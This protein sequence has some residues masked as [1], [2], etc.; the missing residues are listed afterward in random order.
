LAKQSIFK[1]K[2]WL[3]PFVI[4][5][6]IYLVLASFS[7]RKPLSGDEVYDLEEVRT[8]TRGTYDKI[9]ILGQDITFTH[10]PLY[11]LFL[12]FLSRL[13]GE[14]LFLFRSVGLLTLCSV[15]FLLSFFPFRILRDPAWAKR[16]SWIAPLLVA[17]H[18]VSVQGSAILDYESTFFLLFLSLFCFFWLTST[19]SIRSLS[20]LSFLY[21]LCLWG[22]S[23]SALILPIA[24]GVWAIFMRPQK[25]EVISL[26][27]VLLGGLLIFILSWGLFVYFIWGSGHF[28]KPFA[29]LFDRVGSAGNLSSYSLQDRIQDLA[30]FLIWFGVP[31]LLLLI[32]SFV[33][34]IP[35]SLS[36][37]EGRLHFLKALLFF[38]IPVYHVLGRSSWGYPK[39]LTP[40]AP[41]ATFFFTVLTTEKW[42]SFRGREGLSLFFLS[43][44]IGLSSFLLIGDPLYELCYGLKKSLVMGSTLLQEFPRLLWIFGLPTLF[45]FMSLFLTT[46]W[47]K[48]GTDFSPTWPLGCAL[49]LFATQLPF[50]LVQAHAPY[51]TTAMYGDEKRGEVIEIL[52]KRVQP[53]EF[54]LASE[55]VIPYEAGSTVTHLRMRKFPWENPASFLQI[56]REKS[57]KA[58]V[59]SV[60]T[61]SLHSYR[62]V[63]QNPEVQ[64]TLSRDF[65]KTVFGDYVLW[66]RKEASFP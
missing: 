13:F 37:F 39:Y 47:F 8:Y 27:A 29:Y 62:E 59:Y 14:N 66:L 42:P 16:V 31:W 43:A 11:P 34:G 60:S 6:S 58:V 24:W 25:K 65:S 45:L 9:D 5:A 63:V 28:F 35:K 17:T 40:F 22:R 52:K 33:K 44:V 41:L 55:L 51:P 56:L 19:L 46:R 61:L 53:T 21:A 2:P 3:L 4:S 12:S 49:A 50:A 54:I 15:L 32:V 64:E 7:I 1:T 30:R 26:G 18:P 38:G 36:H 57:P 10:V 23:G 20:G 48:K